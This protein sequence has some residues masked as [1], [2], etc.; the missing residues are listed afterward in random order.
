M[1]IWVIGELRKTD[2]VDWRYDNLFE[3]HLH[4]VVIVFSPLKIQKPCQHSYMR[5]H[6]SEWNSRH[7]QNISFELR[8]WTDIWQIVYYLC[9][10]MK[11]F[12]NCELKAQTK[13]SEH[14]IG[15][16]SK[17]CH[18]TDANTLLMIGR[19]NYSPHFHC[20]KFDSGDISFWERY[21]SDKDVV[22]L[23][24]AS[25]GNILSPHILHAIHIPMLAIWFTNN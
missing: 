25:T 7:L 22:T 10:G 3:S 16:H 5:W 17:G 19:P 11:M 12:V 4:T 8:E 24:G 14:C 20:T 6:R 1:I 2:V 15:C 9:P 21:L 13:G 23:C 18:R